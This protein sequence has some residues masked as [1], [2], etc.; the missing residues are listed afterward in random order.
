MN[1]VQRNQDIRIKILTI[2]LLAL[3]CVNSHAEV[4]K[5]QV[6]KAQMEA[7]HEGEIIVRS[8]MTTLNEKT[9][10]LDYQLSAMHPKSCI[11]AFRKLGMYESYSEFIGFVKK[12]EFN[13]KK[14]QLYLLFDHQLLPFPISL[15]FKIPRIKNDGDYPFVFER[16]MLPGLSGV[17]YITSQN[18]SSGSKCLIQMAA[19][20]QGKHTGVGALIFELFSKTLSKMGAE[21][22]IRMSRI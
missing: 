19:K 15:A 14:N 2:T 10:S 6:N 12:S 18:S 11:K 1:R 16:G 8:S 13:P 17:V 4:A 9:Q 3:A 5:P 7:L 21:K 22:L 20:W